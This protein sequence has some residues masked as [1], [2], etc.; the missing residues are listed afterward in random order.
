MYKCII[1]QL[2]NPPLPYSE[3]EW[4]HYG[5]HRPYTK[6]F[7]YCIY[8]ANILL[9]LVVVASDAGVNRPFGPFHGFIIIG[10]I[11]RK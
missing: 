3:F 11:F 5:I 7:L 8:T 6:C 4:C 1:L 2:M 10:G 9:A